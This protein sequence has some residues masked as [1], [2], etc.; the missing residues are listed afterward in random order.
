MESYLQTPWV[1]RLQFGIQKQE[2]ILLLK[3]FVFRKVSWSG[4]WKAN[5]SFI[6]VHVLFYYYTKECPG[7][8]SFSQPIS[9]SHLSMLTSKFK[10]PLVT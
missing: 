7:Q 6:Y 10:F 5:L 3:V 4:K 9:I 8:L 2:V 1:H